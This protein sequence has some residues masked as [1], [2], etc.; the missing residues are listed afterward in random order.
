MR[1]KRQTLQSLI[2]KEMGEGYTVEHVNS[3]YGKGYYIQ[4]PDGSVY[5]WLGSSLEGAINNL[6]YI[7][8]LQKEVV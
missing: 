7:L 8:R 2:Q 6:K 5:R 1:K 3:W 4:A